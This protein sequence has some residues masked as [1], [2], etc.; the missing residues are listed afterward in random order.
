MPHGASAGVR[1]RVPR[2]GRNDDRVTC[3]RVQ[4]GAVNLEPSLAL[5]QYKD[6]RVWVAM[7]ARTASR[8]H[9]RNHDGSAKSKVRSRKQAQVATLVDDAAREQLELGMAQD[10]GLD[11]I[12]HGL[13]S[14]LHRQPRLE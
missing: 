1:E 14:S 13:D 9:P 6:L 3:L 7:T 12:L 2:F 10:A 11:S 8:S 5:M 4:V